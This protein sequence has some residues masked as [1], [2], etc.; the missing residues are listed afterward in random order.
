MP[1]AQQLVLTAQGVLLAQ[2]APPEIAAAF[3]ETRLGDAQRTTNR[4]YGTLP[5][6]VDFAAVIE[7][8]FAA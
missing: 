1:R 3:I 2:H 7:R 8:A 5:A 4:V 6:S